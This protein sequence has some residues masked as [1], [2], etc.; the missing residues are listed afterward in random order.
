MKPFF[1][2]ISAIIFAISVDA[3]Y[4]KVFTETQVDEQVVVR[5]DA[6]KIKEGPFKYTYEGKTIE[7]GS[8]L[9]NKKEGL[10]YYDDI[11][12]ELS[13]HGLYKGGV[14][15]GAWKYIHKGK[16]ASEI[17]YTNGLSDSAIG[18]YPNSTV[19]FI[20]HCDTNGNGELRSYYENGQLRESVALLDRK[21]EGVGLIYHD[22]GQLYRESIYHLGKIYTVVS[23]FDSQGKPMDGG[24]LR[25]GT[26]LM[27]DYRKPESDKSAVLFLKQKKTYK[28]G[29]LNGLST[30]Y[31][32]NG[33]VW[34]EGDFLNDK[35]I[36]EWK[37]YNE[38]GEER[39]T[40]NYTGNE[41]SSVVVYEPA[42]PDGINREDGFMDIPPSFQGGEKQLYKYLQS[43]IVYPS[44]A[45]D[46][47]IQGKVYVS[48]SV[49][50]DG[51]IGDVKIARGTHESLNEEA[52]SVVSVMPRWNPGLTGGIPARCTFTLPINFTLR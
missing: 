15:N 39:S 14:K 17:Y 8:Y 32:E 6:D 41:D 26:G 7:K 47:G 9:N 50:M 34:R 18:Y 51:E 1:V 45:K 24:D 44:F 31:H 11:N 13:F 22:N 33:K 30:T 23:C 42:I 21:S 2:F 19:A 20:F 3:Q 4:R 12:G 38:K 10:W 49:N 36:G 43:N 29:F 25:E 46:K 35:E 40:M 27:L 16:L 48:F 5:E 52:I 37:S 28:N